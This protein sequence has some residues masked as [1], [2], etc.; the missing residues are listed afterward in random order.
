VR[1]PTRVIWRRCFAYGT[2]L[3]LAGLVFAVTL[4]VAGDVHTKKS[5]CPQPVPA[6]HA[7][8]QYR[9]TG[10]LMRSSVF[11]WFAVALVALVLVLVVV[12]HLVVGCSLGK[13]IFGIRVVRVDGRRPGFLPSS[14]RTAAWVID[15]LALLLP[16]GLWLA[17]FTKGHRRV[18]DYLAGTYVV[19]RSAVG[20]PVRVPRRGSPS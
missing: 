16:L 18:G 4:Y 17:I 15:G 2:G 11:V 8:V 10:Y 1:D 9:S 19:E 5:G 6:G 7:C 3:L 14:I 13:A 12:P 20:H